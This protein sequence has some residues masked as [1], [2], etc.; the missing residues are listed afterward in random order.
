[1][2]GRTI[3]AVDYGSKNVGLACTDAS[4]TVVRPLQ[5]IPNRGRRALSREIAR[6]AQELGAATVVVGMPRNMDGTIGEAVAAVERF[7]KDLRDA[8]PAPPLGQ[9]ERLS[10]IEA[11]ELWS[12]MKPRQRKR[13]RSADSLAAALILERFLA[14]HPC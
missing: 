4:G 2:S 11:I 13:Y 10:T 8:L 6:I 3:L 5:S 9:D 1:M 7:M 12:A 14:E